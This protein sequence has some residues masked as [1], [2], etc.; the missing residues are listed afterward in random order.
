MLLWKKLLYPECLFAVDLFLQMFIGWYTFLL[1]SG[2]SKDLNLVSFASI[3]GSVAQYMES[4]LCKFQCDRPFFDGSNSTVHEVSLWVKLFSKNF[5]PHTFLARGLT[6]I[7]KVVPL[8]RGS[9]IAHRWW[10]TS[11][12]TPNVGNLSASFLLV[13]DCV[14]AIP[15]L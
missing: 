13:E 4:L 5:S 3:L 12:I 10:L 2:L 8:E 11:T 15:W 6:M 7:T 14:L 1:I 9:S